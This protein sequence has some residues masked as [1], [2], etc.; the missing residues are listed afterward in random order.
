[1]LSMALFLKCVSEDALDPAKR[2]EIRRYWDQEL[3]GHERIRRAWNNEVE[4]HEAIRAGWEEEEKRKQEERDRIRAGFSWDEFRP[5]ERCLRHGARQYSARISNVP[6]EYDPVQACMETAVEIHGV[7]VPSPTHCEDRGCNGV[8]GHW[9]VDFSEPACTTHFDWFKDKG[10]SS[11]GSGHRRIE[12]PL[13]NLQGGD[14]WRDMCSTTPADFRQLH[15]DSPDMC[16]N[17]G[18]HGVWGIWLIEDRGC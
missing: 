5:D 6:R 9:T 8:V 17:W 12:S 14:A 10:C 11:E 15:F 3:K 16:E 2:D 7:E 1:M 18:V 4:R 13:Q